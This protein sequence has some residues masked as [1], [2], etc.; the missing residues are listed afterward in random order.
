MNLNDKVKAYLATNNITY[1]DGSYQTV[2]DSSGIESISFWDTA[3]L[4]EKPTLTQLASI[5]SL[6][7][8]LLMP[9]FQGVAKETLDSLAQS[10]GY[11]N[12]VSACSY[13]NSTN[14]KFKAEALALI[15][16]RDAIWEV[17]A[18]VGSETQTVEAFKALL[19][20]SPARPI[21]GA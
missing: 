3:V 12:I 5:T 7:T 8:S 15:S 2:S 1:A 14:A 16:W 9:Q 17:V 13:A 21:I 4:G 19:P 11:D 20:Q 18:N 10:W 6:Q